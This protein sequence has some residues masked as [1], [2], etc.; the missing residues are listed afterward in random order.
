MRTTTLVICFAMLC[1]LAAPAAAEPAQTDRTAEHTTTTR[2]ASPNE[3]ASY[4]QRERAAQQQL[5]FK[6][7]RGGQIEVT[8]LIIILLFVILI[9]ILV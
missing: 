2:P 4:A 5:K 8:T 7:G 9:V 3:L 1:S 6:G